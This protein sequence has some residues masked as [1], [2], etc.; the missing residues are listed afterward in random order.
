METMLEY[1][2]DPKIVFRDGEYFP[3]V[4]VY[5]NGQASYGLEFDLGLEN[6]KAA[7]AFAREFAHE[8]AI[9]RQKSITTW[10]EQHR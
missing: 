7:M 4:T 10:V 2:I 6:P 9:I 8:E 3:A 1:T 5:L